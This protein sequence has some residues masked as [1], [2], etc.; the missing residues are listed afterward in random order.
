M[1]IFDE[2]LQRG[3]DEPEVDLGASFAELPVGKWLL[4]KALPEENKGHS[5]VE[6]P[7]E[8]RSWPVLRLGMAVVGAEEDVPVKNYG[9]VFHRMAMDTKA[10]PGEPSGRLQAMGNAFL[11]AGLPHN[12]AE[13]KAATIDI[14]AKTAVELGMKEEDYD[15][16]AEYYGCVLA[17][18]ITRRGSTILARTYLRKGREYKDRKTG[19]T[20]MSQDRVE[21]TDWSDATGEA[22]EVHGIVQWEVAL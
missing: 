19:E 11:A 12:S 5:Q 7:T 16:P 13:R 3:E 15:S 9:G 1:G 17:E 8:T 10:A 18:A 14:L 22:L 6:D 20:K 21:L 2:L 4:L